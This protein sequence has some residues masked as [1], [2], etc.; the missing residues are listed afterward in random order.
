[1]TIWRP[2]PTLV[3]LSISAGAASPPSNARGTRVRMGCPGSC[4]RPGRG[5]RRS[6]PAPRPPRRLDRGSAARRPAASSADGRPISWG[7]GGR[8]TPAIA[9]G[10]NAGPVGEK[11]A[12]DNRGKEILLEDRLG[13]RLEAIGA[14]P[15]R[16][17]LSARLPCPVRRMLL[18]K[19]REHRRSEAATRY[20]ADGKDMLRK[21]RAAVL[22]A[23]QNLCRKLCGV[24]PAGF[25][26]DQEYRIRLVTVGALVG[27]RVVPIDKGILDL[28]DGLLGR[29]TNVTRGLFRSEMDRPGTR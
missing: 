17:R 12:R 19:A 2:S 3:A 26:R 8:R 21:A 11:S 18:G 22:K 7:A 16:A 1:M 27:A 5:A 4:P 9:S 28:D 29:S 6:K 20:A 24:E 10:G 13:C 14:Q 25:R 23:R 15:G